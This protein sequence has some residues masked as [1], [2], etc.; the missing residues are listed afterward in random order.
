MKGK[1]GN[2]GGRQL[3]EGM[4][5]I[6]EPAP[7][8]KHNVVSDG[9]SMGQNVKPRSNGVSEFAGPRDNCWPCN[10]VVRKHPRLL[11]LFF[12]LGGLLEGR[13]PAAESATTSALAKDHR[14]VLMTFNILHSLNPL[15]PSN[16]SNRC[17]LVWQ[18]ISRHA[19][20]VLVLQE[21]LK[22]QL[23]DFEREFGR[24]YAWVGQGHSGGLNGEILPIAWRR[25]RFDLVAHEFFWFSPTPQVAGSIG[26][27][28]LF[29]R[30]A[31][32][33]RLRE[34]TS[35]QEFV[36]VNNHWEADRD[37]PEA[38][39]QSARLLLTKTA[40]L[41]PELPV[42]LAGDFNVVPT[43][44]DGREPYRMLTEEGTPPAFTDAWLVAPV[45][46]G[47]ATTKNNLRSAPS[48][49]PD[50]RKDWVLVRGPVRLHQ[51]T[52][53]DYHREGIYPSDHLPVI[54]EFSW[55][56]SAPPA[57]AKPSTK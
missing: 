24:T 42:F 12:L 20:D 10:N 44:P 6:A 54:I 15:P 25:D 48:L 18:V 2:T 45:R 17:P 14:L 51:A 34:K 49:Q 56:S 57:P 53:D 39:R 11:C 21:V 19:P 13:L 1:I 35:G 29:P 36:V 7:R 30:V 28:G 38:R 33:A 46:R 4:P 22:D 32:W 3:A 9:A 50:K 8:E 41:P 43:R 16:W 52:V 26:W 27:E 37:L 55:G 31:T 5:L 47:P 40:G 23:K